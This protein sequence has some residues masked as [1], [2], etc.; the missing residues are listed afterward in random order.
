MTSP[1]TDK[2]DDFI[3]IDANLTPHQNAEASGSGSNNTTVGASKN[4]TV[5]IP[6]STEVKKSKPKTIINRS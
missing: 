4:T 6:I 5:I 3:M 2:D 1:A